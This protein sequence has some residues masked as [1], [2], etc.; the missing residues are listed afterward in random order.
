[1][2]KAASES[3]DAC[4]RPDL[5]S[6]E[7]A[8]T[9]I[10]QRARPVTEFVPVYLPQS[11]GRVLA[12]DVHSPIDV[13]EYA[14][15]AMDGYALRSRD[16]PESAQVA[17]EVKQRIAAGELGEPLGPGE[18]ARIFTGA[19]LPDGADTVVMQEQC[20]RRGDQVLV[21]GPVTAGDNIRPRGND[22][23][24]GSRI[25]TRGTRIRPQEMGLMASVG[26][27]RVDVIRRLRVAIFSSGDELVA[28]GLPLPPGSIYNSNRYTLTGLL[29]GLGCRIHDLGTVEDTLGATQ[30][31]LLDAARHADVVVT[32]GGMSVGEEDH[33]KAA[34]EAV[35]RLEMWRIAVKP[36]K[37][38]AYG[39]IGSADFLGLPGNPVSTL[40]TFC[41]F[42]RPFLLRRLG[43]R[44]VLPR[45]FRVRSDFEWLRPAERRELVRA[46]LE[47]K[48]DGT[49]VAVIYP[50]QG[51]DVMMS[52]TWSEGL[53]DIPAGTVVRRGDSM[54]YYSFVELLS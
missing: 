10:L 8:R 51:S 31:A 36:G 16:V 14:N 33:V 48:E 47:P 53:I 23:R 28:P 34:L 44:D 35:G 15:S 50:K 20:E 54:Q 45:A 41:L 40:V 26:L 22:I 7:Q 30:A 19:P 3:T 2:S 27:A 29:E 9:F 38:L 4:Y 24:S 32:S 42:V 39:R 37:P 6:V 49:L 25:L 17:L 43:V 5:V 1:M 21:R 12:C 13:P 46:R 11:L 18:S 52:T